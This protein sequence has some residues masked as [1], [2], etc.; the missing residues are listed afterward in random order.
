MK[1]RGDTAFRSSEFL[2]Q[3]LSPLGRSAK[4]SGEQKTC[5]F[6]LCLWFDDVILLWNKQDG[7]LR[8]Y[9]P[10]IWLMVTYHYLCLVPVHHTRALKNSRNSSVFYRISF[11]LCRSMF[12]QWFFWKSKNW[13]RVICSLKA[14]QELPL[15]IK[16]SF[17]K[18][19][20]G[21]VVSA[22]KNS[23]ICKISTTMAS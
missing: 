5:D 19:I 11:K 3:N 13:F 7:R 8:E 12:L 10:T 20:I 6:L 9:F 18:P 16:F 23:K 17:L 2:L 21:C 15:S 22:V 4:K 14:K 1:T